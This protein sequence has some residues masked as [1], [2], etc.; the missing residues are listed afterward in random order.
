MEGTHSGGDPLNQTTHLKHKK[1]NFYGRDLWVVWITPYFGAFVK[2][3]GPPFPSEKAFVLFH[4]K[5][6]KSS[7]LTCASSKEADAIANARAWHLR[8]AGATR[9]SLDQPASPLRLER[10]CS[11]ASMHMDVSLACT[12]LCVC[13]I[14]SASTRSLSRS[15]FK[16]WISS[17]FIHSSKIWLWAY[18]LKAQVYVE[19]QITLFMGLKNPIMGLWAQL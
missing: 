19:H 9:H 6:R 8:R 10:L 12:S 15:W 4:P 18:G 14:S 3:E 16:S 2:K 7:A 11:G 13:F 17:H 1:T 5:R